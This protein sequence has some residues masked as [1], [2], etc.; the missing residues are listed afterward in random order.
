[1][2]EDTFHFGDLQVEDQLFQEANEVLPIGVSWDDR[3]IIQSI[4][5]LTPSSAE[6][7]QKLPS[8]FMNM[9]SQ[10][11]LDSNSFA[12]RLSEPREIMFGGINH[13]LYTGNFTR[14]HPA[15]QTKEHNIFKGGWQVEAKSISLGYDRRLN[16]SL[17]GYTA[18]FSTGWTALGLPW[19]VAANFV[20]ALDFENLL[21]MPPSVACERRAEMPD[22]SINLAG[23]EFALSAF[24]YTYEWPMEEGEV[25][26]VAAFSAF[27]FGPQEKMV[28]LGSSFLRAFYAVFDLDDQ[29]I[30]CEFLPNKTL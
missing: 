5:S 2:A 26:C 7:V 20:T 29:S 23:H 18:T 8:P 16:M 25:R 12:L 10:G 28:V 19:E 22:I 1:M 3:S 24:D 13:D 15:V 27:E 9:V 14:I 11:I 4:I 17:E 21:F 6:S 30:G